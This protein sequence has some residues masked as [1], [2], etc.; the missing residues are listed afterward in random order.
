MKGYDGQDPAKLD[1]FLNRFGPEIEGKSISVNGRAVDVGTNP[2]TIPARQQA[3]PAGQVAGAAAPAGAPGAN[4]AA[5]GGGNVGGPRASVGASDLRD[6]SKQL[7]SVVD[8]FGRMLDRSR[9]VPIFGGD[10][11]PYRA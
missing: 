1:E 9:S 10:V 3:A 5:A 4:A 11:A 8:K 7:A 2:A 6:A